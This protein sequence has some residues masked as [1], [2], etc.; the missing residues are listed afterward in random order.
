[1]RYLLLI[2]LFAAACSGCG[3]KQKVASS[4]CSMWKCS[5]VDDKGVTCH[6]ADKK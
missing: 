3:H 5:H 6:C 4:D 2:F 1:M